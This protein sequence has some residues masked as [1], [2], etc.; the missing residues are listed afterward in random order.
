MAGQDQRHRFMPDREEGSPRLGDLV[1]IR[2]AE[3]EDARAF[4]DDLS[5]STLAARLLVVAAF[6]QLFDGLQVVGAGALRGMSDATVPMIACLVGYWI[7][8]IPV[9]YL[10]AFR[11]GFGATGIWCGL[12]AALGIVGV[13]LFT[14]FAIKS[15]RL[16]NST[17]ASSTVE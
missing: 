4:V 8:F 14:R 17:S 9:A 15:A 5:V 16:A 2:R 11:F 6:F 7:V 12:A 10:A 13:S 1:R 3:V